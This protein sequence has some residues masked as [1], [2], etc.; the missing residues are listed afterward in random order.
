MQDDKT[1]G[2]PIRTVKSFLSKIPSVV[3]GKDPLSREESISWYLLALSKH[4]TKATKKE[5]EHK[6]KMPPSAYFSCMSL[7]QG[8]VLN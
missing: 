2:V 3:T 1:G 8:E 7:L 6:K 4:A 5:K